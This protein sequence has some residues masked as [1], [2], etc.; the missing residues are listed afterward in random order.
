[1]T[2]MFCKNI[3]AENFP[4]LA[5]ITATY[6]GLTKLSQNRFFKKSAILQKTDKKWPKV[7]IHYV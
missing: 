5:Q 2:R 7:L 3:F 1:M 6:I 4:S